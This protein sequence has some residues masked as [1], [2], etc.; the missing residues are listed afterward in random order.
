MKSRCIND[1]PCRL[2]IAA[3]RTLREVLD[4][5]LL[6]QP[7]DYERLVRVVREVVPLSP[8][9]TK[10]GT[11]GEWKADEPRDDDA[12]TW[13]YGFGET[14]GILYVDEDLPPLKLVAIMAHELGH[15]CTVP[16]DREARGL[17]LEDEWAS[18]LTADWYAVKRWRFDAEIKPL[19]DWL[20][21]QH[22]GS[23]P[24][25]KLSTGQGE[26][27]IDEDYVCRKRS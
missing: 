8:E 26:F 7:V 13:E 25:E 24:G 12:A 16:E 21:P 4:R 17:G 10:D 14:P 5:I 11:V 9:E 20:D 18:E 22:H 1:I 23:W 27:F 19:R 15:A 6:A 2:H 3:Q